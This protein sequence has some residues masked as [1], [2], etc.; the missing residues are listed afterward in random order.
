MPLLSFQEGLVWIRFPLYAAAVQCWI[1]QNRDVRLSMLFLLSITSIIMS[2]ILI[3]E[4]YTVGPYDGQLSWPYGDI[5]PG[6]FIAKTCMPI[7]I[8][9]VAIYLSK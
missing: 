6:N 3:T 4:Y 8:T 9:A 7:L 5:I 1:A 2:F